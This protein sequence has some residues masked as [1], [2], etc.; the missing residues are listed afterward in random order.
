MPP[1]TSSSSSLKALHAG[2]FAFMRALAQGLDERACWDRYLCAE[3][4][5]GDRR[6]IQHTIRWL[7]DAFAAAARQER[8]PGTARLILLDPSRFDGRV[9][10]AR[11][12]L[13][14]FAR[15]Q[16]LEDFSEAE[17]LEAYTLAYP[18][19]PETQRGRGERAQLS[20]RARV[21]ER[22]LEAIRWLETCAVRQP[23]ASDTLSTWL[24]P[25]QA[26]R[27]EHHGLATL[28]MLVAHING[29]GARWWREVRGIGAGKARQLADWLQ[30]HE[31]TIG[32]R[33][34][35]HACVPMRSL[36]EQTRAEVTPPA[37]ALVPLDKLVIPP[38]LD[39]SDGAHRGTTTS[40]IFAATTDIEAVRAWMS[41]GVRTG[42]VRTLGAATAR[43]YRKEAERLML[44][45]VLERQQPL[46]SLDG[47]DLDA[48][49]E[50][51]L[52]PPA[53]WCGPR[54]GPRWSAR[55][56]PMEG[57]LSAAAVRQART[58]VSGLF[59]FLV[60]HEWL[61]CHPMDAEPTSATQGIIKQPLAQAHGADIRSHV[62]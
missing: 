36:D 40:A 1:A 62:N 45:C 52:A 48:Y 24:A 20:R 33:L 41:A 13:E 44:W 51:L 2:H 31:K 22:Q 49:F 57:P 14:E 21:I 12:S 54:S 27:L 47:D 43:S 59:T 4:E 9:R 32:L 53:H 60:R 56:R 55:W 34:A 28:G 25:G 46:S 18:P 29:R 35:A 10:S 8:R 42:G 61:A 37:T 5:G 11:P 19:Q 3:G 17:Q 39:G 38:H 58:I 16:G 50:F 6:Q 26:Q 15:D 7:R 23:R 30:A